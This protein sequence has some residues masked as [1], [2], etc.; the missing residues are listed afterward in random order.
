MIRDQLNFQQVAMEHGYVKARQMLKQSNIAVHQNHIKK[1]DAALFATNRIFRYKEAIRISNTLGEPNSESVIDK[2]DERSLAAQN[3]MP[4]GTETLF[5]AQ[6]IFDM[7][8]ALRC[9]MKSDNLELL[10]PE[11]E[12]EILPTAL[13][14]TLFLQT[15][16]LHGISLPHNN[17]SSILNPALPQ[18]SLYHLRYIKEL[19]LTHNRISGLPGNI[20]AL[21]SLVTLNLSGNHLS[22]LP[23]SISRLRALKTLD[24]T[25]N[26][27]STLMDE[28]AVM[29]SLE[30][31]ELQKNLFQ[32]IPP[33][34]V[35]MRKIKVV[36]MMRNNVPHLAVQ[37]TLLKPEDLWWQF[38]DDLTGEL[39]YVNV[40][41][42]ETIKTIA[43]YDGAG[44]ARAKD[45]HTF[46]R[47]GTA[48]YR[49]RK[50]WLSACQVHEW[51]DEEDQDSG[52]TYYRNNVSGEVHNALA[53]PH[54]RDCAL[55]SLILSTFRISHAITFFPLR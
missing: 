49:R 41:T 44:I 13:G 15:S 20:G 39:K 21:S 34:I 30:N 29:E 48:G 52:L 8:V 17:I 19:N 42:K 2:I 27:F 33:P 32:A 36:N 10:L 1:T 18:V 43:L 40:L 3:V 35:R 46:Q 26:N 23:L 28:L 7:D 53:T 51:D 37:T 5:Q 54:I 9:A 25:E 45:L 38:T 16:F 12:L 31:I 14:D 50:V 24:L 22:T 47:P 55:N 6:R 4:K 11:C